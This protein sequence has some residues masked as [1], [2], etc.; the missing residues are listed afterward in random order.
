MPVHKYIEPKQ[1]IFTEKTVDVN[2]LISKAKLE[3]KK[4]K[5]K[6][7]FLSSIVTVFLLFIVL[8]IS[9]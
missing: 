6:M 5:K 3:A 8:I 1:N 4:E 2:R 7:L 9:Y